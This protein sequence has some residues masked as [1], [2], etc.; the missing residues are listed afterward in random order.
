MPKTRP[1]ASTASFA[2]RATRCA[3]SPRV[4][5]SRRWP[6]SPSRSASAPTPPSS[7]WSTRCACAACP[8]RIRRTRRA[9]HHRRKSHWIRNHRRPL[10]QLHHSHVAGGSTPS[11]SLLR[12]LCLARG[13]RAG[14]QGHGSEACERPRGERRILQRARRRTIARP[15]DRAPGRVLMRA[16]EGRRQLSILEVADGRRTHYREYHHPGRRPLCAGVGRHAAVVHRT[17]RRR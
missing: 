2:T 3:A 6:S 1:P 16:V 17:R 12:H 11:R 14:R 7:N 9:A 13:R 8:S 15:P 4:A 10:C 5:P